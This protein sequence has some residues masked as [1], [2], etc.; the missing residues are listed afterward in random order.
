MAL[1]DNQS[2]G[3]SLE[4]YAGDAAAMTETKQRNKSFERKKQTEKKSNQ[5]E[6]TTLILIFVNQNLFTAR[7]ASQHHQSLQ[8]EA[9]IAQQRSHAHATL[10]LLIRNC[11][12][13]LCGLSTS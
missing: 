9:F 10:L 5:Q 1:V 11:T 13:S 8:V 4:N 7:K 3:E 12:L 2:F 6:K